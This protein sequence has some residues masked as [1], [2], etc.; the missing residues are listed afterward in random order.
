MKATYAKNFSSAWRLLLDTEIDTFPVPVK[1]VAAY[2]D[3][4][5]LFYSQGEDIL[6]DLG[7]Y[8]AAMYSDGITIPLD[9]G[10]LVM[11]DDSIRT[12]RARVAIGHELGHIMM[13]HSRPG[14]A[15]GDNH[16]PRP[17]D[18]PLE[19]SANLWCEQLIAPTGVLLAAGITTREAIERVCR[20]NRRASDFILARLAERPGYTPQNPDEIEVVRRFMRSLQ[21]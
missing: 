19:F 18:R 6:H 9:G 8:D 1:R 17:G 16:P 20:V 4:P 15:T 5:V 14:M 13:G 12:P 3:I 11:Y 7:L 10:H 21:V 2:L